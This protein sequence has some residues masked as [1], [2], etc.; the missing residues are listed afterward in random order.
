MKRRSFLKAVGGVAGGCMLGASEISSE[1]MAA[2]FSQVDHASGLPRRILG[3]TGKQVSIVG[4]P[5][6]ALVHYDQE[7]CN[8]GIRDAFDKGVNY[9]DVAPAYGQGECEIK[10]GPG[11]RQLNR[12][13]IFLAC[14]TKMR[15][16]DGARE[17]LERS[18][19]R[20][21]TDYFDLYQLHHL[22]DP[23]DVETALGPGGAMETVL[24]AREEGKIKHIG[25][26]A[27]TTKAALKVMKGFQFDTVMFPINFVEYYKIGF[28]KEVIK[29]ANQQGAALLS[30]KTMSR[31]RWPENVERTR[32]WW[33]Q[34]VESPEEVDL[35][36]RFALSFPGVAAG[37]P[38]SFLDLLDKLIVAGKRFRPVNGAETLQLQEMSHSCLSVFKREEDRV[39]G[40]RPF[41]PIYPDSPYEDCPPCARA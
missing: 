18:L 22:W 2:T 23:R 27:H 28:G 4:F 16:R 8:A 40:A 41:G 10:M 19:K 15:D 20:L 1:T 17:E 5:G 11:L 30:I 38:P 9:F 32:D 34:P 7:R 3:R 21:E 39:A 35:A 37:I 14:K 24:K 12:S 25:F 36:A 13:E 33:Y 31:G 6:L 26:S 29:L